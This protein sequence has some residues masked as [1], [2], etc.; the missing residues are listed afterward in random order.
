M[1]L[2]TAII[3]TALMGLSS[4]ASAQDW[5]MASGY[6]D[7]FFLTKVIKSFIKD[8]E[9]TTSGNLK[10]TLHDNQSLVRLGDMKQAV[11]TGQVQIG[12]ILLSQLGNENPLYELDNIP[13]LAANFDEA[14]KLWSVLRPKVADALL[15]SEMRLLYIGPWPT[16][17][18]YANGP[19]NSVDELKGAKIR[20]YNDIT[21]RFFVE[22]GSEPTIVQFSE[23]PQAFA[24]GLID[25]MFTAPQL[26]LALKCWDFVKAFTHVGSHIPTNAVVV[27]ESAFQSLAAE[28]Q[29]ALLAAGERAEAEAW[30]AAR[31][32][33]AEQL[34]MLAQ[35]GMTVQ[36]A[37]VALVDDLRKVGETVLKVWLD[38]AGPEGRAVVDAYRAM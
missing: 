6:S 14:E 32:V 12:E 36:E 5:N 34:G 30:K 3:A 38:K 27:N 11:Q 17:G 13:F 33:L 23:V 28:R 19:I 9:D 24:T 15:A 20:V 26:C 21:R 8:V 10:I 22:T 37:N 16:S 31:A 29:Q 18:F 2:R 35:N 25:S 1:K 4:T 7:A